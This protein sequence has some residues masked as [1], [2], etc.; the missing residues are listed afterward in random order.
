VVSTG[1]LVRHFITERKNIVPARGPGNGGEP[2]VQMQEG[3]YG[4]E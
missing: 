1:L 2:P 4:K 3:V